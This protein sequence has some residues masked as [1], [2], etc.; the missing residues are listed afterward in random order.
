MNNVTF[1]LSGWNF[2]DARKIT[3]FPILSITHIIRLNS[4]LLRNPER[5][6][7]FIDLTRFPRCLRC[8]SYPKNCDCEVK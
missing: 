7:Q 3:S 1:D 8:L 5:R 6:G 4:G 2:S